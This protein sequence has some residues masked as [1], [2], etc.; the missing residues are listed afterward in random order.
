MIFEFTNPRGQRT[1]T[2]SRA[3]MIAATEWAR[4]LCHLVYGPE[5][6]EA[7]F[8][9]LPAHRVLSLWAMR[10]NRTGEA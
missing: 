8:R 7:K 4:S 2:L 9:A 10:P 1:F 5:E 3:D 6:G